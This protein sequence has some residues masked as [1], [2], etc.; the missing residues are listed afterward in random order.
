MILILVG[1]MYIRSNTNRTQHYTVYKISHVYST[2]ATS[3]V[4][5]QMLQFNY[6]SICICL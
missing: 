3:S 1:I 6:F 4:S 5:S 2:S